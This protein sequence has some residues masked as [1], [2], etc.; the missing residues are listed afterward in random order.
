[1]GLSKD[2]SRELERFGPK[3]LPRVKPMDLPA[4][5]A[6]CQAYARAHQENFPVLS[7]VVPAPLMP[8]FAA[9]YS[10]CRWSD[11]LGDEVGDTARSIDLLDWWRGEVDEMYAGRARHPILVALAETVEEFG[12]PS[13]PLTDLLSA[14][15]Q[16]QLVTRYATWDDLFDYCR[17]SADPVGRLVLYLFRGCTPERTGWSDD[18]CTGLQLANFWQDVRVDYFDRGRIYLPV[19]TREKH[20]VSDEVI[21]QACMTPGFH[22]LM[23]EVVER[24]E[25]RLVRGLSL[26]GDL[27]VR[28]GG[29]VALFGEGGRAILRRIRRVNY[30]VLQERPTLSKLD[31][32]AVFY[33]ALVRLIEVRGAR[34][35]TR[36]RTNES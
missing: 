36:E 26:A 19:I 11:D 29:L 6:Y 5:Q 30:N 35:A 12:I 27:P 9:V 20:G 32:A 21:R 14:F 15:R 25:S 13:R 16:D 18:I 8:H 23:E 31:R 24:A 4:A 17:R 1:M 10:Y 28:Q 7:W 34:T 3:S 2:F 22:A 33:H